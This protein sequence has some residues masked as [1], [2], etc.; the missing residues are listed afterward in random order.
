MVPIALLILLFSGLA[1]WT[2]WYLSITE[3]LAFSGKV[4]EKRTNRWES[5]FGGRINRLLILEDEKGTRSTVTVSEGTYT[6]AE[7]G[8]WIV[9]DKSG[10]R[11]YGFNPQEKP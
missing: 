11:L 8:K 7:I 10:T 5:D 6:K 1:Y 9:R 4:V 3:P 2:Y